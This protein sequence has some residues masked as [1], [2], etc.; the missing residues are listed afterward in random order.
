[1]EAIV[2]IIA[3]AFLL[4]CL[5]F[6][7]GCSPQVP[8]GAQ[9]PAASNT[10]QRR[11]G[12]M[13]YDVA[14][15]LRRV[16]YVCPQCGER[17]L[18][19]EGT[20]STDARS[21]NRAAIVAAEEIPNCRREFQRLH[22]AAGDAVVFDESQ[23]CRHCAPNVTTPKLLLHISYKGNK[24][25]DV[26]DVSEIDLQILREFFEGKPLTPGDT[27]STV[28]LKHRRQRLQELLLIPTL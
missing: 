28:P 9:P 1:M 19:D 3:A 14:S 12:A 6:A 16:D 15:P 4:G 17:T 7:G 11:M 18:Y 25:R 23:F 21:R 13:C 24:T 2:G 5:L 26:A 22:K 10:S 8:V 20:S 27:A